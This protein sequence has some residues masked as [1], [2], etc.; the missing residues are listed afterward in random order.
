MV[1][2]S[3]LFLLNVIMNTADKI[4]T[5]PKISMG[6]NFD[7]SQS[8]AKTVAATGSTQEIMLA[9]AGPIFSTPII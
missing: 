7:L 2:F 1:L 4:N 9:F 3:F 5:N 6:R 8:A